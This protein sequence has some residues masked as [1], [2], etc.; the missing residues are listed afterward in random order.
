[1]I[2]VT[3]VA[4]PCPNSTC[5]AMIVTRLSAPMRTNALGAS[6]A[7]AARAFAAALGSG[8]SLWTSHGCAGTTYAYLLN[9]SLRQLT[10]CVGRHLGFEAL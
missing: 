6:V 10:A 7:V 4:G 2:V 5:L 3:P 8:H 1:M 9:Y